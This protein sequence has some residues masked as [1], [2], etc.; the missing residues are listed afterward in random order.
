MSKV[1]RTNFRDLLN[2]AMPLFGRARFGDVTY[3]LIAAVNR[4]N[5]VI[6]TLVT[7]LNAD[8]GVADTNYTAATLVDVKKPEER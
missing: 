6:K 8:A 4:Q 2:R 1:T 7:K 5:A 3:D